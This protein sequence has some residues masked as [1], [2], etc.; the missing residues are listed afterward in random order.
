MAKEG[1]SRSIIGYKR[2]WMEIR[3][4]QMGKTVFFEREYKTDISDF[5]T[6]ED[7]DEFLESRLGH[8]LKVKKFDSNVI[9]TRGGIFEYKEYDINKA[10]DKSIRR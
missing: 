8:K 5:S 4:E 10:F 1:L 9:T 7:V 6:T 2:C 3:G